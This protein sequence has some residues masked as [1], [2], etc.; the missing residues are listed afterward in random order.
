M[1]EQK[2]SV[3]N[4]SLGEMFVSLRDVNDKAWGRYAFSND[5][6]RERVPLPRQDEMTVKAMACGEE[7]AQ[8]MIRKTGAIN[9][10]SMLEAL[11]LTLTLNDADMTNSKRP[12]YA[13]FIPDRC[14]EIMTQPIAMYSSIY[15]KE[16]GSM[17]PPLLIP[18]GELRPL[19]MAHEMFHYVEEGNKKEIYSRTET[20][21]LWK[22]LFLKLN[23]TV[24]AV[25]EIAAMSFA[26]T[27][28]C[29]DYSP[30]ILDPLMLYGYNKEGAEKV[31]RRI[32]DMR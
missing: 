9:P 31:F 17:K 2:N 3:D 25:S 8:R 19:L 23:S 16:A 7:W 13:Q 26:K 18:P 20:I 32:M 11:G 27:L 22:L 30:F 1:I 29:V 24:R 28:T 21:R 15:E 4:L 12:L 5:L 6:L 10:D 14:I